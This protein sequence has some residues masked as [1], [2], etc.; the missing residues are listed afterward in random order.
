MNV[1]MLAHHY[2]MLRCLAFVSSIGGRPVSHSLHCGTQISK[3]PRSPRPY[4]AEREQY[5]RESS[6]RVWTAQSTF[7]TKDKQGVTVIN[8]NGMSSPRTPL[9][10]L[11]IIAAA[12]AWLIRRIVVLRHLARQYRREDLAKD[13]ADFYDQ[14]SAA[15][16]TVWGEHMHHGLYD[17]V[18]G[19]KLRGFPAQVRTMSEMLRLAGLLNVELPKGG[20]VLDVGCGI[21]G[22]SRFL[23]RH[24]GE[25]C[26]VTGITLSPYQAQRATEINK[27]KGLDGRVK[28]EVRNALDTGFPD[29]H[30]DV[31]WSLESG[32]HMEDKHK[33]MRECSRVL[34]PGGTMIMLVWCIRDSNPPLKVSERFSIRRIMEEYC[35]PRV[36]PASEYDTEMVRSGLRNVVVSDWTKR[37][38][39]FWNEVARSAAFNPKGWEVLRKFGWPLLRSTLAMRH[40]I[41]GIRQGVFRLV[42]LTATK[43]TEAGKEREAEQTMKCRSKSTLP[44]ER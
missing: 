20:R 2:K 11:G 34:K 38:A 19:K 7:V 40:V 27:E 15:W 9:W 29:D 10:L 28:N 25:E 42:A 30:F 3:L 4:Q 24:F 22:A 23:A 41:A 33:F 21:G 31:V 18:N 12:I 43:L 16:E 14:R 13:I 8:V 39:P 5:R 37:A 26:E 32:E 17:V 1:F 36:A 6:R 44:S 35:L